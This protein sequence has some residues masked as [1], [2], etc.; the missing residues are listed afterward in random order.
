M[1][2][3][4]AQV[5]TPQAPLDRAKSARWRPDTQFIGRHL[6]PWGAYFSRSRPPRSHKKRQLCETA[7]PRSS[8]PRYRQGCEVL[9]FQNRIAPPPVSYQ[10]QGF[11]TR[12]ALSAL[13]DPKRHSRLEHSHA[14]LSARAVLALQPLPNLRGWTGENP[15]RQGRQREPSSNGFQQAR[16]SQ[17][18]PPTAQSK[19]HAHRVRCLPSLR[20][21]TNRREES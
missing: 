17:S 20:P 5:A 7:N 21:A 12:E 8:P 18:I 1:P 11:G 9:R 14:D 19:V 3:E 13:Y 16:R 4:Q 10:A 15:L 2:T 6:V